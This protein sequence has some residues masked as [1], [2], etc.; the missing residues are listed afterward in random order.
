MIWG[1]AT[2]AI[3]IEGALDEDGRG[4]SIWD[5]F[6]AANG[7]TPA[8]A[9]DHYHRWPDDLD[10][11]RELGVQSY[12][13]SIA[14]PRI[15]PT[16]RGKPNRAGID[17]YRRLVEGLLEC[18]IE[19]NA[20]LYHWD[21]PQALQDEG[22]WASRDTAHAFAEYAA[23][24]AD[25]LADVVPRWAT[26]NE[27][28]VTTWLGHLTGD[29]APGHRDLTEA[30]RVGHHVLLS[31]G[32]ALRELRRHDV[33]AGIVLD[34]TTV[35]GDDIARMDAYRNRFFLDPLFRGEYPEAFDHPDVV[36]DGDLALISQPIDWLGVNYYFPVRVNDGSE[37]PPHGATTAMGWEVNAD[38]FHELLLRLQRDYGGVPIFVTENGA[39]YDDP[40]PIDGVVEDPARVDYIR[41]HVAAVE[42]AI[43][44]GV[45]VRGYYVWSLLDNFEWEYGYD[46]RFGIVAV[47][48]ETQRRTPKRSALWYR[49]L[50]ASR[51]TA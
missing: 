47:D 49:D 39:A 17:F 30:L 50:I 9:C 41:D 20:T 35:Y 12:R 10:L 45:D 19:P 14:W 16:G 34:L 51:R 1:V 29:K 8:I 38:A 13:F 37:L 31:H 7:D 3:Q 26:H 40:E 23:L 32:L 11:M 2:A 21:L 36:E 48:Y 15:L 5:R 44:D 18:G 46:K 43:A 4:E 28:A 42:R 27:P 24:V 25:E 33:E 6:P 22:G